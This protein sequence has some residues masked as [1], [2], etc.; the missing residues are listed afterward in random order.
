MSLGMMY[1]R[2]EGVPENDVEA[3][4]W[5]RKAADLGNA[6]AQYNL[7]F[8]YK[9]G[10]GVPQDHA[11]AYAWFNISAVSYEPAKMLKK[12]LRLTPEE[13][14]RGQ[15]RSTELFNEIEARKKKAGK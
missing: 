11:E 8:M 10:N 4:K 7:G 2:G 3:V 5:W 12:L 14:E 6:E 15:K 9:N 13:R 1:A